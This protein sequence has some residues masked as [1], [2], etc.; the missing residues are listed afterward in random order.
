VLEEVVRTQLVNKQHKWASEFR[1][2]VEEKT[3]QYRRF[4]EHELESLLQHRR[5][6]LEERGKLRGLVK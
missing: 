5:E 3:R 6:L 4:K 1:A 2:V